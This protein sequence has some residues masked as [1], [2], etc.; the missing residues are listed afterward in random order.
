MGKLIKN[1]WA[2]L[3]ILT[4]AGYQIAASISAF[5]WPKLFWDFLTTN[6]DRAVRPIPIL[7]IL[8]LLL[9]LLALC[10][11]WPLPL[12]TTA[13]TSTRLHNNHHLAT[14]SYSHTSQKPTTTPPTQTHIHTTHSKHPSPPPPHPL[15]THLAAMHRSI[16]ARLLVYPL[17]SLAA[18]LLYQGT[19]AGLYYV[20][21]MGVYFWAFSEGEVVMGVP[22][23]LP[24]R[25][26]SRAREGV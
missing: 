12:F 11:E 6:L 23:T 7:Q 16:E 15:T 20:V 4:A 9:G 5:F 18:L 22:W 13:A 19:N 1:H 21:G 8:N 3:I 17:S 25:R 24:R 14:T 2:R 10:W 26:R